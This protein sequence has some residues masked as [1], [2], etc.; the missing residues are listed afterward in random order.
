[1]ENLHL[2]IFKIDEKNHKTSH[3]LHVPVKQNNVLKLVFDRTGN[4]I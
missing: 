3:I 2:Q 4:A 1:M